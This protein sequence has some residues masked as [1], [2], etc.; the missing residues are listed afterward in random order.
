[1]ASVYTILTGCRK[2]IRKQIY[3]ARA[4]GGGKKWQA[5][6]GDTSMLDI[7]SRMR[8]FDVVTSEDP[9]TLVMVHASDTDYDVVLNVIVC[10]NLNENHVEIGLSDYDAIAYR[11]R[12]QAQTITGLNYFRIME[13]TWSKTEDFRYMI[14]P[15]ITRITATH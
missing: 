2:F 14:I 1:M 11:L 10:Y 6:S 5:W 12:T 7:A 4:S 9:P 3:K 15:I 13:A 8:V